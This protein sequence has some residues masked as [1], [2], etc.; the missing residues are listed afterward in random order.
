MGNVYQVNLPIMLK[1]TTFRVYNE[2]Q[3]QLLLDADFHQ[4]HLIDVVDESE[5]QVTI[6]ISASYESAGQK[7]HYQQAVRQL[8][9]GARL[10]IVQDRGARPRD[11]YFS[12]KAVA[13]ETSQ[14]APDQHVVVLAV[15]PMAEPAIAEPCDGDTPGANPDT[16]TPGYEKH[17]RD[18]VNELYANGYTIAYDQ[19]TAGETPKE[20]FP[21]AESKGPVTGDQFHLALNLEPDAKVPSLGL[22]SGPNH[23]F[24]ITW[25]D[26]SRTLQLTLNLP[27]GYEYRNIR[28]ALYNLRENHIIGVSPITLAGDISPAYPAGRHQ[29]IG[30]QWVNVGSLHSYLPVQVVIQL[31]R[32]RETQYPEKPKA[33]CAADCDGQ[34]DARVS[35]TLRPQHV[36]SMAANDVLTEKYGQRFGGMLPP[37]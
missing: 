22:L 15:Y 19:K 1:N 6:T 11:S 35:V 36:T 2:D 28:K 14:Y 20:S 13:V 5:D 24:R 16:E 30:I 37:L 29:V 8:A 34:H 31:E 32:L 10:T 18:F 33:Q 17:I 27:S 12:G 9:E 7:R 23:F 21:M 25:E 3:T 26:S 4:R